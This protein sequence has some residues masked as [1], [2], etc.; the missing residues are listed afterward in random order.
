[1]LHN[2]KCYIAKSIG[3]NI[4]ECRYA[5]EEGQRQGRILAEK[6][7]TDNNPVEED[8]NPTSVPKDE[9]WTE[10]PF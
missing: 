2:L 7:N 4:E 3:R 10:K 1:M 8:D 5:F 6:Y 9:G